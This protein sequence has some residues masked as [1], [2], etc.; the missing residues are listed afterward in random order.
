MSIL[1][2]LNVSRL[3]AMQGLS[4]IELMV[5]LALLMTFCG[6]A[7]PIWQPWITR[8]QIEATRDQ[9]MH[10]LQT[11][12]IQAMQLGSSLKLVRLQGCVWS[13]QASN[14]WSCG[15]QVLRQDTQQMMRSHATQAPIHIQFTGTQEFVIGT[16]GELGTVGARWNLQ[17]LP[18]S[19]DVQYVV[20]L[21]SAGRLRSKRGVSCS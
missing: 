7:S 21:N 13:S 1:R 20:C 17:A 15:W 5:C 9:L 8:L 2:V 11:A 19:S 6:L 3:N 12:R 16:N 4:L 14:D 18:L 10:E